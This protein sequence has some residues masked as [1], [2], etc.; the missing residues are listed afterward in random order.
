[1]FNAAKEAA[2]DGFIDGEI[3]FLDMSRVVE[4]VLNT[5]SDSGP[6]VPT[7]DDILAA[8]TEAR[9]RAAQIIRNGDLT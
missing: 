3:G 6:D 7:L 5:M 4:R 1:V 8:D 2:L 9:A